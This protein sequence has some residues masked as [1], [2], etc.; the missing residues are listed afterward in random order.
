MLD[1]AEPD[2]DADLKALLADVE[3][4]REGA[5]DELFR[6]LYSELH[7]RAEGMMGG[8]PRDHT[9]QA[10]ALVSEAF[11][12]LFKNGSPRLNDRRHFLLAASRAMRHVLVDYA[13]RKAS[14]K[15]SGVRSATPLEELLLEYDNRSL[16]VAELNMALERLEEFDPEMMR[17]VELRFFGGASVEETIEALGMAKRTFERRWELTRAWLYRELR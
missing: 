17:A 10:T 2:P 8:Q 16:D 15:R 4:G 5:R 14:D 6:L 12:R 11:I 1:A 9:L 7:R 3:A 13:R